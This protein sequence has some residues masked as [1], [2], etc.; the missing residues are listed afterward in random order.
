MNVISLLDQPSQTQAKEQKSHKDGALQAGYTSLWSLSWMAESFFNLHR[1]DHLPILNHDAPFII[2][3]TVV[4]AV[5]VVVV[6]TVV[7]LRA[8]HGWAHGKRTGELA[9]SGR[10]CC[11]GCV[12]PDVRRRGSDGCVIGLLSRQES[13]PWNGGGKVCLVGEISVA[14]VPRATGARES[15]GRTPFPDFGTIVFLD[16]SFDGSGQ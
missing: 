4:M 1:R 8:A 7:L 13:Q 6:M 9:G 10:C 11:C 14:E 3:V 5:V 16:T 2:F 15:D 12:D